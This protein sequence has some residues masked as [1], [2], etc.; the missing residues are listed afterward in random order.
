MHNKSLFSALGAPMSL[1]WVRTE[2]LALP[3]SA[4]SGNLGLNNKVGRSL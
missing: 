1:A 3:I 4:E 2:E